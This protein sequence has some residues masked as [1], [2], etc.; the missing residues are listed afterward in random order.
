MHD[1]LF[2]I[3]EY[4]VKA[5]A[6][7]R[8]NSRPAPVEVEEERLE[9]ALEHYA[10]EFFPRSARNLAVECNAPAFSDFHE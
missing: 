2:I 1:L 3:N 9:R 4:R 7:E 10:L 8:V 5:R 6:E